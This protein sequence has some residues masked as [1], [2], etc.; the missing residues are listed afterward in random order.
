MAKLRQKWDGQKFSDLF[1]DFLIG[2]RTWR[3]IFWEFFATKQHIVV[4]KDR[5]LFFLPRKKYSN[6]NQKQPLSVKL[7][8]F[9]VKFQFN[10][11]IPEIRLKY[12]G[13]TRKQGFL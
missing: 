1:L 10:P 6:N 9:E 2:G 5:I 4:Q 7:I 13:S 3:V 8:S 11:R 12:W